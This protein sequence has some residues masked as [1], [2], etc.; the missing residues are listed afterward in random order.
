MLMIVIKRSFITILLK[1][2]NIV[3]PQG[4]EILMS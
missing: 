3:I 2:E 1:N 4:Y